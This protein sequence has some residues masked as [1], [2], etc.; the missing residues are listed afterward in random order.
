MGA[1]DLIIELRNAGYSIKADGRYLDISPADD[2]PD[3]LVEQ[4]KQCKAEIIAELKQEERRQKALAMLDVDPMLKRVVHVD[5]DADR[6]NA[7]LTIAIRHI[8]TCEMLVPKE[9]FDAWQL[10]ALVDEMGGIH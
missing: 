10:L 5:V 7:I 3:E 2:L 1:P 9:R 8:A 4:L 6:D